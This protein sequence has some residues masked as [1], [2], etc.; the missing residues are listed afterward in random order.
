MN[1]FQKR[2]MFHLNDDGLRHNKT[3]P[4]C[5]LRCPQS[6]SWDSERQL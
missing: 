3:R 4:T 5:C 2:N 6:E 1:I